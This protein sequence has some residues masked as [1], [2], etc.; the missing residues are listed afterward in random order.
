MAKDNTEQKW[1]KIIIVT[2][3]AGFIGSNFLNTVVSRYPNELFINVDSLT[4][5]ADVGNLSVADAP[6][7]RFAQVDIRD[8]HALKSLFDQYAPT[9]VINFAAESHVDNSITG[10]T[11]FI[12]TNVV[13]THNLLDLSH[14]R[15]VKRFHQIS[16]DEVYGSLSPDDVPTDEEAALRPNS[17]YSASKTSA[18]LIVRSY[19]KTYALDTVITRASNNYGPNQHLEK[20]IPLF[21]TRLLQD[22]KVPLYGSGRNVRDWIYVD[23]HVE[24]I[25]KVFREGKSGEIYNLGGGME[26]ENI[27]IVHMLLVF[28]GKDESMIEYVKDRPGHD[29]RY[30]LDSNKATKALGW[31]PKITL[32][33]GLARTFAF[34]KSHKIN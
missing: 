25:D 28:A 23:D 2:G 19:H 34:Y 8:T 12:E 10:P 17:P 30:A 3:G 32:E 33:E 27:E 29:I 16:T 5:A 24:G 26:L 31:S 14:K 22:K 6:N 15:G 7:Y 9:H 1:D 20:L 13:G 21:I 18:D 4:Y 11:V